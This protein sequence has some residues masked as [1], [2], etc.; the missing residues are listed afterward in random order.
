[1]WNNYFSRTSSRDNPYIHSFYREFF[2]KPSGKRYIRAITPKH[3]TSLD[4]PSLSAS[5]DPTS[6]RIPKSSKAVSVL[7]RKKEGGWNERFC[8]TYSQRNDGCYK[9]QREYFDRSRRLESEGIRMQTLT[10][11]QV[12]RRSVRVRARQRSHY[13]HSQSP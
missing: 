9:T 1:M 13:S 8:V 2:D 4:P 10:Y 11:Q 3:V 6:H 12:K 7:A 5:L